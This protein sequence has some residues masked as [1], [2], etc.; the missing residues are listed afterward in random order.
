MKPLEVL[1][2]RDQLGTF[3]N[4]CGLTGAG[5]EIGVMHG[6]YSRIILEQWRGAKYYMV[7]L[8]GRQDPSVYRENT[9]GI[10]YEQKYL[11][12]RAVADQY[13]IVHIIR[14]YSVEAAKLVPDESLDWVFI[15]ANHAYSAVIADMD[16]W[17]PKLKSGGVFGGHDYGDDTNP[18]HWCEVKSAVDRWMKERGLNFHLT[19]CGSWWAL[20]P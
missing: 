6:G 5:A 13:P 19:R 3:L 10:D 11:D 15:D 7:D 4:E 9:D 16:A 8:W 17:Y 18:P 1:D 2:N 20:K 12:C 14:N